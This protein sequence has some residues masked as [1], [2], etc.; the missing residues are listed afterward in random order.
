MLLKMDPS[1]LLF[2][3][4]MQM[5]VNIISQCRYGEINV[6]LNSLASIAVWLM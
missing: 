1:R 2:V 3:F 5:V 4:S 6:L